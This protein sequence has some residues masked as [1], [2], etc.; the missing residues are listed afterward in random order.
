[1]KGFGVT[2]R[3][4]TET[5]GVLLGKVDPREP[6]ILH[7]QDFEV[8]ACEY[9]SGPSYVLSETDQQ[10][11]KE[12]V[13]KWKPSPERDAYAVGYFR[14]H[15]RPGFSLDEKD[16]VVMRD[17]FA[18]PL[19]VALLIKPFAT[20]PAS[21]GFFLK[22]EGTL[23]TGGTPLE[24]AFELPD[25]VVEIESVAK[26]VVLQPAAVTPVEAPSEPLPAK[27][28]IRP[29]RITQPAEDRDLFVDHIRAPSPWVRIL[30]RVAFC[31]ALLAFGAA[32]G[33]EFAGRQA[34]L[35]EKLSVAGPA[36]GLPN[37][38]LYDVGL[39]V[40]PFES[41]VILRWNRDAAPIQAALNGVLT[42]IE[43]ANSRDV[44]LGFAE[45]RNGTII[46]PNLAP[47]IRFRFQLL[48]SDNRSFVESAEYRQAASPN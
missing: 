24:F 34:R 18:D 29:P 25:K 37:A 41:G 15:T 17:F 40:S 38:R 19:N 20:R 30:S 5:G 14:S 12:T 3:R 47:Q 7:I 44:K 21:A 43:G 48:F 16:A 9:A 6:T 8:V 23:V 27:P 36:A 10:K 2:R 45:L 39:Q 1:M 13:A 28:T 11:F 32:C 42:V 31:L 22:E 26:P 35:L 4:G 46:Y 33:Y